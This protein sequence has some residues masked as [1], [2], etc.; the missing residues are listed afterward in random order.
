MKKITFL[1][2]AL[3]PLSVFAQIDI[4]E[5]P[6][7][8]I[9]KVAY[10]GSF[11]MLSI[12]VKDEVAMGLIGEK[13]TLL[14]VP[15]FDVKLENGDRA[16]YKDE[17]N[18]KNKTY[19]IVAYEKDIYP[20][21][22]I[23]SELGTYKWK[24]SSSS[25]YIFNK[26]L[27]VIKDKLNGKIYV[28][29]H[30]TN[31]V[32]SLNGTKVNLDGSKEYTITKVSFTKFMF[33]YGI[34]V[35]INDDFELKY[36]TG[37]YDQPRNFNGEKFAPAK[38]WVNLKGDSMIALDNI[39]IEKEVFKTFTTEN[40]NYIEQIRAEVIKI[41]MTNQQCRWAWGMPQKSFGS[42]AGYDEVFEWGGKSLYF[43]D[44]KLALIR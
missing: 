44:D 35:T 1:L 13:V 25:K 7:K 33:D 43:N 3:I 28:P 19:E 26:Y 41:G 24:V 18:F 38:G 29:L 17:D 9:L 36:P 15:Y 40:A 32:E 30:N 6:E 4:E 14:E 8:E 20:T 21:Y 27:D 34:K 39:L 5:K 12:G 23:K 10:D 42:L 31:E 22:T 16:S 37:D 2:I 11:P